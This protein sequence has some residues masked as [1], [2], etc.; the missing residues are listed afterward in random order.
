MRRNAALVGLVCLMFAL[1]SS[2]QVIT[3]TIS[4]T[5]RDVSG[6]VIPGVTIQVQNA[7]TGV[8]RSLITDERGFYTA[9]NISPGNYEV[10]ASLEGFQ[11]EVRRG[12]SVNV[13]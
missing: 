2:G 4:G 5:A 1:A 7:E 6:A 11:T 8:G 9:S 10:S 3:G 12:F 13:G